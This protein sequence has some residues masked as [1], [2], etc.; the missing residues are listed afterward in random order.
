M[1]AGT[2]RLAVTYDAAEMLLGRKSTVC[3]RRVFEF[4]FLVPKRQEI[5]ADPAKYHIGA[6]YLTGN[7]RADYNDL[8]HSAVMGCLGSYICV[9]MSTSTL[10]N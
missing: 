10:A 6:Y 8:D 9:F 7:P 3:V 4:T 5:L 2:H 1:P